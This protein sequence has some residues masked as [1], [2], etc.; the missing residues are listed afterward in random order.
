MNFKNGIKI[1]ET[2]KE[3][4]KQHDHFVLTHSDSLLGSKLKE[5]TVFIKVFYWC[6]SHGLDLDDGNKD[7]GQQIELRATQDLEFKMVGY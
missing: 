5:L 7:V 1:T 6:N 4:S 2:F 3:R